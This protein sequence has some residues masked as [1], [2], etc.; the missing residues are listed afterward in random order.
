MDANGN[1]T[2]LQANGWTYGLGYNDANRLTVVQRNGA[3]LATYG[4]NGMGERVLKTLHG[5]G[6]QLYAYDEGGKLLYSAPGPRRDY[7][8]VGNTLVATLDGNAN[9]V[10]YVHTDQLGTPRAVT[11][12]D[13]TP[14]WAWP[15]TRNPFGEAPASGNGY[16]LN[17]RFPGQYHDAET[18]LNYNYYRDYEPGTGRYIQSDPIGLN[19]GV[20]SY[21]YAMGT[22]LI[23]ADPVGLDVTV[24]CRP[25][26]DP[27]V[28]WLGIVHCADFVWHWE[29]DKCGNRRKVVDGQYSVAGGQT[30]QTDPTLP[31][32]SADR[33]AFSNPGTDIQ[34]Y[35]V[36]PPPGM[37]QQDWDNAV[38]NAG[39]HYRSA[40]PYDAV[41]G[42]NSNTA[43]HDIVRNAGGTP[44]DVFGAPQYYRYDNPQMWGYYWP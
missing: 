5:G 33:R 20:S 32:Y 44:P 29:I 9:T 13:G 40:E 15:Y 35:P 42:P 26:D 4:I 39:E 11:K 17:L 22:P 16:S 43:A 30:P 23:F 14:V 18:G 1:T 31:T 28:R 8:W 24:Q 6:Q 2:A 27:R 10:Y 41:W 34:Q 7:V 19:G 25:I 21:A 12:T 36:P 38:M 37:S 3:T